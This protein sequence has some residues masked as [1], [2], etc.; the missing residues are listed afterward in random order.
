MLDNEKFLWIGTTKGFAILDTKLFH[1]THAGKQP[2]LVKFSVFD[3]SRAFE[4]PLSELDK[5]DLDYNENFF[6]FSVSDF[7]YQAPVQYSF[8][9]EGFDK[10]WKTA[11][12]NTG[13]YT[14]VPPGTYPLRIKSTDESGGWIERKFPIIIHIKPPFWQT[15]WFVILIVITIGLLII[16]VYRMFQKRKTKK[17]IDSAIDYFAN[18]QFG[19]NSTEICWNISNNCASKLQLKDC[20]VYL[21]DWYGEVLIQKAA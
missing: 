10:D 13:S 20:I 8:M 12:G 6:S 14:N 5:I 7:N 19:E 4:K 17:Q 1:A 15:I 9:L 21:V 16:P 18:S 2:Q 3:K 11:N